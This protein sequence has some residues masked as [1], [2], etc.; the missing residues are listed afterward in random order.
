[1]Y[2]N[3]PC[4]LRLN[5]DDFEVDEQEQVVS[6]KKNNKEEIILDLPFE[7]TREKSPLTYFGFS[8][9]NEIPDEDLSKVKFRIQF[10]V[11][12]AIIMS[13][14]PP[15]GISRQR[16]DGRQITFAYVMGEV[17]QESSLGGYQLAN[18]MYITTEEEEQ[19]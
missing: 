15:L 18:L 19:E 11:S 14:F 8:A 6:Q 12:G 13:A 10:E 16:V 9:L 5:E 17:N 1:M 4:G 2:I 7:R 3:A